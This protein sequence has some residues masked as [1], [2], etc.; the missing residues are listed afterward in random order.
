MWIKVTESNMMMVTGRINKFL[1]KDTKEYVGMCPHQVGTRTENIFGEDIK[2]PIYE[3]KE[4]YVPVAG[5]CKVHH[6][7]TDIYE[8]IKEGKHVSKDD[9]WRYHNGAL[10]MIEDKYR[11]NVIPIYKGFKVNITGSSMIIKENNTT[12]SYY[13]TVSGTIKHIYNKNRSTYRKF[14][15]MP[16]SEED[17]QHKVHEGISALFERAWEMMWYLSEDGYSSEVKY[18][19]NSIEHESCRILDN[20]DITRDTLSE[21]IIVDEDDAWFIDKKISIILKID[22]QNIRKGLEDYTSDDPRFVY[23]FNDESYTDG[24]KLSEAIAKYLGAKVW[25]DSDYDYDF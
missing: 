1:S 4:T 14:Y 20:L 8:R 21:K 24:F 2:L 16:F 7:R 11:D 12:W 5:T 18:I 17:T 23:L 19:A 25:D 13:D 6:V 15:H 22:I 3:D 10:L 9:L